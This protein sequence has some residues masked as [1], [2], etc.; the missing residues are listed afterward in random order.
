MHKCIIWT[1]SFAILKWASLYMYFSRLHVCNFGHL[2]LEKLEWIP[3]RRLHV[4]LE[5]KTLVI[6]LCCCWVVWLQ[7]K[8]HHDFYC[9]RCDKEIV[10]QEVRCCWSDF[11]IGGHLEIA[12]KPSQQEHLSQGHM[13][14]CDGCTG[15]TGRMGIGGDVWVLEC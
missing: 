13:Y 10:L 8:S 6:T 15:V 3:S 2:L 12:L 7:Q 4:V 11:C 14:T 5:V 1:I 9:S